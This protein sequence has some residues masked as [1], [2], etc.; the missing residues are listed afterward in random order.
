MSGEQFTAAYERLNA[1]QREAVDTIEGPVMVIAG[2]GTGK[3][4]ILTLRIANILHRSDAS[5][6]AILALTFT[7]AGVYA[8]RERLLSIIGSRAHKVHIHTFHSFCNEIIQRYPEFFPRIIGGSNASDA[9]R[10][11]IIESILDTGSFQYIRPSGDP[12]YYVTGIVRSLSELKREY[13]NPDAFEALLD[14]RTQDLENDPD[15]Y[16]EKGRWAGKMKGAYKDA[17]RSLEKNKELLTVYRMYE[18]ALAREHLFDFDDMITE[19]VG[20]LERDGDFK[21]ML[22]EEYQYI[23]ADEHQDA[24]DSQ[25]RILDLLADFHDQPN[26]FVVGDTKQAIY[27]FQGASKENFLRFTKRYPDARVISLEKNYRSHQ[28]ILDAAHGLIPENPLTACAS[29][30][31]SMISVSQHATVSDEYAFLASHIGQ[32]IKEGVT[33]GEIAVIYRKNAEAHGIARALESR[34]IGVV[35]ESKQ[36]VLTIPPVCILLA[37]LRLAAFLGDDAVL[38]RALYAPFLPLSAG[39][40]HELVIS[41][42]MNREP[43]KSV[44]LREEPEVWNLFSS[45]SEYAHA[46]SALDAFTAIVEESGFQTW[47]LGQ[48]N[49]REL[50][51]GVT[52]LFTIFKEIAQSIPRAT[53]VQCL[54][55]LETTETYRLA[56]VHVSGDTNERVRLMTAH[57]AK[58]REFDYVYIAHVLESTWS[59][60]AKR[61]KFKLPL[62]ADSNEHDANED[63]R[64]LLYVALTRARKD[65][66]LSYFTMRDDGSPQL[67]SVFIQE[68]G[69][70]CESHP[71]TTMHDDTPEAFRSV[72]SIGPS[73]SEREYLSSIFSHRGL[74]ATALNNYL[75]CPWKYFFRNLVRLPEAMPPHL[76]Y[77]R[78]VHKALEEFFKDM[79]NGGVPRVAHLISVFSSALE[80]E[81]MTQVDL[82][83]FIEKGRVAL[84]GYVAFYE[85]NWHTNVRTEYRISGVQFSDTIVLSGS[86]D[87]LEIAPDG[88][89]V[90]VVDYK[91]TTPKSRNDIEGNTK[92]SSGDMKRQ[93]VFYKLLLDRYA[94]DTYSF[95]AGEIDFIEPTDSGVYKKERFEI[96]DDEVKELADTIAKVGEEINTL[97]FWESRCEDKACEFCAL[98]EVVRM[99]KGRK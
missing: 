80:K 64:R 36:D 91:T 60:R 61:E 54:Q 48:H 89:S 65:L 31:P 67:P 16:H 8:M 72:S 87:K 4:Q 94:G 15:A 81:P 53:L 21:M 63:E 69:Q 37:Q 88:R 86:L 73:I 46:R 25:N 98:G 93:L 13:I 56:G 66:V 3:T 1:H 59:G 28:T 11:R 50:I 70:W 29:H 44:V 23:L 27:R 74:S 17:F 52:T 79:N 12:F 39:R 68:I 90:V 49:A 30:S 6:D 85:P 55:Y 84:E 83:V 47:A 78:A 34:G 99:E 96:Q 82:D 45:W 40:A 10:Y 76:A 2:P 7:N 58:G 77:G 57:K 97:S 95:Q 26:L 35:V 38:A 51:D 20:V 18:D 71:G 9:L 19:V 43:I 33:P 42:R 62:F 5:P 32:R 41:A 14:T 92:D 75:S 22:Q 24:N